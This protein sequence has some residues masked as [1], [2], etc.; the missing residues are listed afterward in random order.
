[1]NDEEHR[2]TIDAIKWLQIRSLKETY[3]NDQKLGYEV[4]KLVN[5][6]EKTN[7]I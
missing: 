2:K 3:A 7:T 4:R 5:E 6:Y 1:M